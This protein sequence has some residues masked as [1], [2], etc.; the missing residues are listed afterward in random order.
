MSEEILN[1]DGMTGKRDIVRFKLADGTQLYRI[2]PPFGTNHNNIPSRQIYL[3]WGHLKK[4]GKQTPL[5]CS[6]ATEGHCPICAHVKLQTAKAENLKQLGKTD[7]SEVVAKYAND[8]KAKRSFLLNAV[9]VKGEVGILEI[10]KTAIDELVL[11]MK[12]YQNK[13]GRNP[14]SLTTGIW[15]AFTRSG[16]KFL[17]EYKVEINKKLITLDDGDTVEKV[18]TSPLPANVVEN[19]AKLAYDIHKMYPPV[20]AADLLEILNGAPVDEVLKRRSN[21]SS[22]AESSVQ[23]FGE[24]ASLETLEPTVEAVAEPVAKSK[25]AP[26]PAPVEISKDFSAEIDDVMS[27]L[28]G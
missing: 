17:T 15:F 6:I 8:F 4:D 18:D 26:K 22:S 7:E 12:S 21:S 24:Y 2:L 28:E 3:H 1:L 5:L 11:L 10:P 20:A 19:F 27:M 13:Y 25:P 9:N 23:T 14:V 16:K